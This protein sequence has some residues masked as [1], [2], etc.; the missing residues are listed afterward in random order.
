MFLRILLSMLLLLPLWQPALAATAGAPQP[1]SDSDY[2]QLDLL[3]DVLALV[4]QNYV[5]PVTLHDMVYG[6]IDGLLT[7]LDPHSEFMTPEMFRE[8][9]IETEGEFNGLGIE[10]TARDQFITVI[11]PIAD[12][13]AERAGIRAGDRIVEINGV[14]TQQMSLMQAVQKMRGQRG[15]AIDLKVAR[16]GHSDLL[17]FR[18]LREKI[19]VAST[20][21]RTLTPDI[22]YLRITQFQ[23][24]TAQETQNALTSLAGK[25]RSGLQGLV[26]DLRNNPGGLLE[27]AVKVADLFLDSGPIVSTRGRRD[28]DNSLYPATSPGTQPRYPIVILIDGGS[29]SAAEI[30]AGALQDQKR[31]LILG[32]Q[33]FG[34]GSVQTLIPLEDG[35]GLRLTTA[36][37]FTPN[38]HSIQARGITPD[39]VVEPARWT[40]E[41][42]AMPVREKDLK[43][44][45]TNVAASSA[46]SK[47]V[48]TQAVDRPDHD[49]TEAVQQDF[50]LLRA[51]DILLGWARFAQ[52]TPA[53]GNG[54]R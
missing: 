23:M 47:P 4:Q 21:F 48:Q 27:Q 28:S 34:K 49:S 51:T 38:G 18:L 33:S 22:G 42:D 5:E 16:P 26:L 20:K 36:Q 50:P 3:A 11:A 8:A 44:H 41:N 40:V 37:Y 45:F 30:V 39:I 7:S 19:Q 24:S 9:Q 29:A 53:T 15:E 31:A 17:P 2:A 25:T 35:S 6:A 1:K 10:I 12:T 46:P 54:E 32:T 52:L 13:P 43:N 14:P